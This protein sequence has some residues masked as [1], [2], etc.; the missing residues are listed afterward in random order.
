M[1]DHLI[2]HLGLQMQL[3]SSEQCPP[4]HLVRRHRHL[5][6]HVISFRYPSRSPQQI[7]QTPVVLYP[8]GQSVLVHLREDL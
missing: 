6:D 5:L 1:A 7:D 2:G 8:R 3:A 4:H